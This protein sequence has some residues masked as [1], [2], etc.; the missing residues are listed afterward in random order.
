MTVIL[1]FADRLDRDS[2]IQALADAGLESK[3]YEA[4]G[5][6][7]TVPEASKDS[8]PF[9][10]FPGVLGVEEDRPDAFKIATTV[11]IDP[12]PAAGS[13]GL[14]RHVSRQRPW[15]NPIPLP[16]SA[17]FVCDRTGKAVDIYIVDTGVRTTHVEFGGRAVN[18]DNPVIVHGHGTL[19]AALAAGA[20]AG[21]APDASVFSAQGLPNVDGS[22]TID[23]VLAALNLCF[24]HYTA[25]D[26]SNR[27]AV[28]SMSVVSSSSLAY[29]AIM[30]QFLTAGIVVA[31]AAGNDRQSL[32]VIDRAPA[33]NVGVINVGAT[34]MD[35]GPLD[36]S[37]GGTNFGTAIDIL[38]AG[39]HVRSADF[40]TD[41]AYGTYSGT[42]IATPLV[43]GMAACILEDYGRIRS[44]EVQQEVG[45]YLYNTA[46]FGEYRPDPRFADMTPA[47]AYINPGV[48]PH[49]PVPTLIPSVDIPNTLS[50]VANN[51][52]TV[53]GSNPN[54]LLADQMQLYTVFGSNPNE[55]LA[56]ITQVYTVIVP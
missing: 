48:G 50:A 51:T 34:N 24:L 22:G 10:T 17:E 43:A 23:Q 33:E 49:I 53:F 26:I 13:W 47:I 35:D 46:T 18:I 29:S 45:V 40:S 6:L 2:M 42:S 21:F 19:C 27:P 1:T 7:L 52:Y 28:L 36:L 41:T 4:F 37:V 8:F 5:T 25:R 14:L 54:E 55:L 12:L 56:E 15:P 39:Q 44:Y 9:E 11:T 16:L 3:T 38:A 31:A 32:S 30:T 20:T